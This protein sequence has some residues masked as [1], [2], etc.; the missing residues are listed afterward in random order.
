[1]TFHYNY[2][3]RAGALNRNQGRESLASEYSSGNPVD[4][5]CILL[6]LDPVKVLHT[7]HDEARATRNAGPPILLVHV[8]ETLHF[9]WRRSEESP[10]DVVREALEQILVKP[11]T[12]GIAKNPAT[13]IV[14]LRV[15]QISA[16]DY[17]TPVRKNV[18]E[19]AGNDASARRRGVDL[20]SQKG[21]YN[22]GGCCWAYFNHRWDQPCQITT[23]SAITTRGCRIWRVTAVG[24]YGIAHAVLMTGEKLHAIDGS[25]S[26]KG[27]RC[28]VARR[29]RSEVAEQ[30][31]MWKSGARITPVEI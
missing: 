26:Q 21:Q 7:V 11:I 18:G 23:S 1:V 9:S 17:L 31:T 30:V 28:D 14:L 24:I 2:I 3:R 15:I 6:V 12:A 4:V 16:I 13:S 22:F 10:N 25:S 5:V 19:T 20:S 27:E 8:L 29:F